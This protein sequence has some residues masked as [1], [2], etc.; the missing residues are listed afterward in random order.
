MTNGVRHCLV[1]YL[2]CLKL[3]PSNKR[4]STSKMVVKVCFTSHQQTL[5]HRNGEAETPGMRLMRAMLNP[6]AP[7]TNIGRYAP[8]GLP[9]NIRPVM[10]APRKNAQHL[11]C[12]SPPR[13]TP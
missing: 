2:C 13:A 10:T 11:A 8:F 5:A 9:E 7:A 4:I 3:K 12:P 1:A 6:A